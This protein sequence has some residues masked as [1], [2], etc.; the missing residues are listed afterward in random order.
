M[1]PIAGP[2]QYYSPTLGDLYQRLGV[3]QLMR[4]GRHRDDYVSF[5]F[6]LSEQIVESV[7]SH[8]IPDADEFADFNQI[9]SAFHEATPAEPIP[10]DQSL[11]VHFVVAT[12]ARADMA[13]IRGGLHIYGERARDWAPYDPALPVPLAEYALGIA[14][15]HSFVSRVADVR[16]L[17]RW[18]EQA[19]RRNQIVVLLVDAWGPRLP[20]TRQPLVAHNALVRDQ[21]RPI[22]AVLIPSSQHDRETRT[23][24]AD[25][26]AECRVVL[27]H[28]ANDDELY[29]APVPTHHLFRLELPE[30]LEVA[31]NRVYRSG[32]VNREPGPDVDPRRPRLD[33]P[34]TPDTGPRPD[35]DLEE[36]P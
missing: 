18:A 14:T 7:E 5:V 26:S 2:I 29:R 6:E 9:P 32:Q 28:L 8:P 27:D 11:L 21:Q 13:E 31:K 19:S 16:E 3:R 1:H 22:T 10:A 12:S 34:S 25:L 30:V 35:D 20:A 23:R 4:L 36:G 17:A 33:G 24:W 15:E